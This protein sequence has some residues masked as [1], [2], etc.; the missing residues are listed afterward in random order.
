M[1]ERVRNIYNEDDNYAIIHGK[2]FELFQV[3]KGLNKKLMVQNSNWWDDDDDDDD[4]NSR[5]RYVGTEWKK[6]LN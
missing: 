2:K 1:I 4:E 3:F 6:L 5:W